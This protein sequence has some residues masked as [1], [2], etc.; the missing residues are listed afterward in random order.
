MQ[1]ARRYSIIQKNVRK[2]FFSLLFMEISQYYQT[3]RYVNRNINESE[4]IYRMKYLIKALKGYRFKTVLDAA[5][6][7]GGLGKL[8]KE[9]W[10][11]KVY[12]ADISRKGVRLARKFGVE[13]KVCDLSEKIPFKDKSFDMVFSSESIEHFVNP[14]KFLREVNRVLKPKGIIVITSPNLSSWL[15]RILFLF[16]IYPIALEAS[17]EKLVGLGIL[18]KFANGDQVVGH[19]HLFNYR[20]LRDILLYHGYAIKKVVGMPMDYE[21][22]RSRLLTKMYRI[23]DSFFSAFIPLSSNY[24]VVARKIK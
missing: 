23:V 16:G 15:N 6:G 10:G 9:K 8:I 24:V 18:S 17:T 20:A 5:C 3:G 14:D 13:A 1:R 2:R 4:I 7:D 21:S 19:I 22:P 12:G 11:V